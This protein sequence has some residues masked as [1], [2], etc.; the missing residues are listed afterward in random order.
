MRTVGTVVRGIR[1]GIIKEGDNLVDIVVKSLLN[2]SKEENFSI[3]DKDIIGITEAV[4]AISERNY[5]TIDQIAKDVKNKYPDGEVGIVFPTP[6]SRNRFALILKGVARA[7]KKIFLQFSYP[8]DHVGNCLFPQG[9]LEQYN[10]SSVSDTIDEEKYDE[11]FGN[12]NHIFTGINYVNYFRELVNDENC[13]IEIFLSNNPK[14]MLKHT[15]NILVGDVHDRE[16]YKKLY[17]ENQAKIVYGT[18]DLLKE[19]VDGSGYNSKYGLLGSNKATEEKVK[20]FPETGDKLVKNIQEKIFNETGKKVEVLVYGDG[21]FKD[22]VGKIWELADPVVSPAYTEGLIGTPNELKLKYLYDNK[23]H[24]LDQDSLNEAIRVE[25]KNKDQ[26]L[27]GSM[28]SQGTTPRQLTDLIGSLCDLTSGS[29]DKGT[30]VVY[31]QGYFDN[32][33]D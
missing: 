11:L 9:L 23:Y 22:P 24:D 31:I 10:I 5:A 13:E 12:V 2:A 19:S 21:A 26:D 4:V 32:Y 20:M 14:E 8:D 1:T 7:S 28:V 30:P 15:S 27:K 3:K 33:A 25:I 17:K 6:V 18:D 16:K 29:G